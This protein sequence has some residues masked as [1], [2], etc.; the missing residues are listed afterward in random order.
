MLTEQ[1]QNVGEPFSPNDDIVTAKAIA[2]DY[3]VY[4]FTVYKWVHRGIIP[5]FRINS[6]CLRFSRREVRA[7]IAKYRIREQ[8]VSR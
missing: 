1:S 8:G 7:A 3:R 2:R 5:V 4:P 6:R